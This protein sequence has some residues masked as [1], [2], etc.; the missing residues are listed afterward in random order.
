MRRVD[1][2]PTPTI[3]QPGDPTIPSSPTSQI[4]RDAILSQMSQGTVEIHTGPPY[5]R[6][7]GIL[8]LHHPSSPQRHLDASPQQ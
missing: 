7:V 2:P 4:K 5:C 3:P 8:P 6:Q 1:G